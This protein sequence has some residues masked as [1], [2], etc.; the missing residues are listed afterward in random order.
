MKT[1]LKYMH[2]KHLVLDGATGTHLQNNGLKNGE[3]PEQFVLDHPKILQT[4]QRKYVEA[5]SDVILTSTF[6]A[7][8]KKLATYGLG[9]KAYAINKELAQISKAVGCKF[10]GGDIGSTGQFI[11][12]L[13][14]LSFE[15]AIDIFK[16]QIRGL[17]DGG[18]DLI[19]IETMLD[20]KE[21]RAALIAAKE[22]C[23]L[24]VF[25]TM[26][27][28]A[29][30]RTL[31]GTSAKSAAVILESAG[32]DAVG[33]NCSTGPKE[34]KQ[35]VID[36]REVLSVPLIVK[37]NAGLP[38]LVDGKTVFDLSKE[39][40]ATD[41][42]LLVDLGA[43]I[44]GGC[45]GSDPTY[46]KQLSDLLSHQKPHEIKQVSKSI[47]SSAFE[48]CEIVDDEKLFIIGE[49]INPTG[50]KALKE[51]LKKGD[52]SLLLEYAA[53]Q[54]N[55]GADI[56]DINVGVAG[57]DEKALMHEAI[58]T[59]ASRSRLPLSIDSSDK[60]V[61][62]NALRIYPGRAIIN[63]ISLEEGK[64]EAMLPLAKKYG[65]MFIL[66]TID[67]HG[68]PESGEKRIR[69][70]QKL[71]KTAKSYGLKK[72]DILVDGL[73]FAISST[74]NAGQET[75]KVIKWCKAHGFKTVLG[76]SNSSY[77][78]PMRKWINSSYLSC[79]MT[80]G[81]TC[82]IINPCE[83]LMINT[84]LSTAAVLGRDMDYSR[85]MNGV[86]HLDLDIKG[87]HLT[88]VYDAVLKGKDA[89]D[90]TKEQIKTREMTDIIEN[91]IIKAL[92]DVGELFSQ[93]KYFL[94]QLLA[95]ASSAKDVLDYLEPL[96]A[97]AHIKTKEKDAFVLATV[98]G[99]VHDIGKNLVGLMLKNHGYDV[100][101]L[102]KDISKEKI[103]KA[104]KLSGAKMV[105][106]SALMTTTAKEMQK[107]IVAL[108][109]QCP[110]TK[111][112][113]GGAVVSQEFADQIGADYYAHDA[114]ES[115]IIAN[116][117]FK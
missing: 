56:L 40:F 95:S 17:V 46:I 66:L 43:N 14:D 102:G 83:E 87:D 74:K 25:V 80:C 4:L 58:S 44:V 35:I 24:P 108:K 67:E 52:F 41:I 26:T 29:Y 47:L 106:L 49:R 12:P 77:G 18:V 101:D 115:V 90:L 37:P 30:G 38:K 42:K 89:L 73:A 75:F 93:K 28:D 109:K 96:M 55:A 33:L 114:A 21:A 91:D 76:I 62:E 36:M 6:G 15:G 63:S 113:V 79:A 27:F 13:G 23:T 65:A 57:L 72:E 84:A 97:K 117:Y 54:A 1:I 116:K 99:D 92:T 32:A 48:A 94:P 78:L 85:Y 53:N 34:M 110:Q 82:A 68:I 100:I 20:I 10:L 7:N 60:D 3:C 16:E 5:G 2:E 19:V 64:A 81:L 69:L 88:S 112:M 107:A 11:E 105:G 71:Y 50:K 39:D 70:I 9:E 59:L 22:V 31:T 111:I 104:V 8:S 86:S 98:K 103:V 51:E 45:C 61:V